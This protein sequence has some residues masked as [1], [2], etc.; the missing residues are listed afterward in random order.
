MTSPAAVARI[1]AEA[2]IQLAFATEVTV[3]AQQAVTDLGSNG[4]SCP[5]IVFE[6]AG[7]V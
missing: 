5:Q 3:A 7:C 1:R 4:R 6:V 2:P